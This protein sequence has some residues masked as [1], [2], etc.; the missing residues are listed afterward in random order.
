M[1]KR[2]G[3]ADR[4]RLHFDRLAEQVGEA[5]THR[6]TVA[7]LRRMRRRG[8]MVAALLGSYRDPHVLEIGSGA[9]AFSQFVLEERPRLQ[10]VGCDVSPKCVEIANSRLKGKYRNAVFEV[11]DCTKL[12]WNDKA[13]DCIC[14]CS[15]L[16][17]LDVELA[18]SECFRVLKPG[19]RI[20]FS[21][22]NMM[23]PQI[24]IQKNVPFIKKWLEDT[25]EETAFFRWR[26]AGHVR[27]A[28][29]IDIRVRPFDFLH[30]SLHG[31][32]TGVFDV[33]GRVVERIPLLK[34]IAGSLVIQ[35]RKPNE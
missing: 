33:I 6:T 25:P 24:A 28:G 14:G 23:N 2:D 9:G 17:H 7:G 3:I 18:L 34:E 31:P 15:I 16:H 1:E 10:L 32:L 26:I 29:F 13:F 19:G 22:P 12:R 20:W 8:R 11:A 21:E 30:P 5:G 35:A 4:E 27:A